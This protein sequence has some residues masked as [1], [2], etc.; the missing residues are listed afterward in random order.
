MCVSDNWSRLHQC[1]CD[2]CRRGCGKIPVLLGRG[3]GG[4]EGGFWK[5]RNSARGAGDKGQLL[6]PYLCH[7]SAFPATLH[8]PP[9]IP[10]RPEMASMS[11]ST[12]KCSC[13][14]NVPVWAC[15]CGC[16][17]MCVC[18]WQQHVYVYGMS[19]APSSAP[20]TPFTCSFTI[21]YHKNIF[22]L[23]FL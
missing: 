9:A 20:P 19:L 12:P 14:I 6:L 7:F 21:I 2:T 17:G 4:M 16:A 15:V 10:R 11:T 5:C 23:S 8:P 3:R 22:A 13:P 1:A 18:G